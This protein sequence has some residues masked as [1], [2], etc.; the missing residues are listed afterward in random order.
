M[1]PDPAAIY[2]N[3]RRMENEGLVKSRWDMEG[4]GPAKRIYRITPEGEE[5]LHGWTITL[6]Q[7]REALDRFLE[8]YESLYKKTE[9]PQGGYPVPAT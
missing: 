8:L 9:Q 6:R 2:R 5:I 3:L 7:R 4:N 1:P